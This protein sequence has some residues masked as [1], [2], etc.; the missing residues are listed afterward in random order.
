MNHALKLII[1][2]SYVHAIYAGI[3]DTKYYTVAT[4]SIPQE[5][6]VDAESKLN[7]TDIKDFIKNEVNQYL[8][9]QA[10]KAVDYVVQTFISL[11]QDSDSLFDDLTII[12]KFNSTPV[13]R[14]LLQ[15]LEGEDG[16]GTNSSYPAPNGTS[17][18]ETLPELQPILQEL[19]L[20]GL[21]LSGPIASTPYATGTD[22]APGEDLPLSSEPG[23][24]P[25]GTEQ[26][27]TADTLVQYAETVAAYDPT[28]MYTIT[29]TS[30]YTNN[31]I[32][33]VPNPGNS[34]WA[35]AGAGQATNVENDPIKQRLGQQQKIQTQEMLDF[36]RSF[37]EYERIAVS[38]GLL[39][40][41]LSDLISQSGGNPANSTYVLVALQSQSWDQM[42][43]LTSTLNSN[44]FAQQ[45]NARQL[46]QINVLSSTTSLVVPGEGEALNVLK[47]SSPSLQILVGLTYSNQTQTWTSRVKHYSDPTH[48]DY[49]TAIYFTKPKNV[50]PGDRLNP[51]IQPTS[52]VYCIYD[53]QVEYYTS[54]VG[55]PSSYAE[56]VTAKELVDM[57]PNRTFLE[58]YDDEHGIKSYYAN[59]DDRAKNILTIEIKQTAIE[60]YIGEISSTNNALNT[61]R[62]GMG[63]LV[64][65]SNPTSIPDA[66]VDFSLY[67]V[68]STNHYTF[69]VKSSQDYTY[70]QYF[71][72]TINKVLYPGRHYGIEQ[73]M[74]YY[75]DINFVVPDGYSVDQG[76]LSDHTM[77]YI[78]VDQR[79][80][81]DPNVWTNPCDI[82]GNVSSYLT[83]EC[84]K[85]VQM[86]FCSPIVHDFMNKK[87]ILV[88][89]RVPIPTHDESDT[90]Q[91]FYVSILLKLISPRTQ[92]PVVYTNLVTSIRL[93]NYVTHCQQT[94][95][96]NVNLDN[97]FVKLKL[98]LGLQLETPFSSAFTV[99]DFLDEFG[100][101]TDA[102]YHIDLTGS[103]DVRS[104]TESL[105]TM[106]A[107]GDEGFFATNP[108]KFVEI[109]QV[110]T[111]HTLSNDT[112]NTIEGILKRSEA[113][114]TTPAGTENPYTQINF[115]SSITDLCSEVFVTEY[116]QSKPCVMRHE[117]K[118]SQV[119]NPYFAH[120]IEGDERDIAWLT[121]II[122]TSSA[123]VD[124]ATNISAY[125]SPSVLSPSY[126]PRYDKGFWIYP[127]FQWP[128]K[129]ILDITDYVFLIVSFSVKT[130]TSLPTRRRLLQINNEM[131]APIEKQYVDEESTEAD[132][133]DEPG[134]PSE[135]SEPSEP[136]ET[137]ETRENRETSET[138]ENGTRNQTGQTHARGLSNPSDHH[139]EV[140]EDQSVQEDDVQYQ[141]DQDYI[142]EADLEQQ[143][144]MD[145]MHEGDGR[146]LLAHPRS[147]TAP[148]GRLHLPVRHDLPTRPKH[149]YLHHR[150]DE[151]PATAHSVKEEPKRDRHVGRRLIGDYTIDE[152]NKESFKDRRYRKKISIY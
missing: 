77:Y 150:G 148:V 73:E 51:C 71:S 6:L 130:D 101:P 27:A 14:R 110:Y 23:L 48:D 66:I 22:P 74:A 152:E 143:E 57:I 112:K 123:A 108:Q 34:S 5:S 127:A 138:T 113:F 135:P 119:V 151:P 81:A 16:N 96:P 121:N 97:R 12:N 124:L 58:L 67:E 7:G 59:A 70:L 13:G 104:I 141:H 31:V 21:D 4:I 125:K 44:L 32:Y 92:F 63:L 69:S 83:E 26:N 131:D 88:T 99:R 149:L 56:F 35:S 40:R 45:I 146:R 79:T 90:S 65:R 20:D 11:F 55:L 115:L 107:I 116:N 139:T 54:I 25:N 122:G 126:N 19:G 145:G 93:G 147:R 75:A 10:S 24:Q 2:L 98:S 120:Y 47:Q 37:A 133:P 76:S 87:G 142:S 52:S 61:Y 82:N 68:L 111:L 103:Q 129:N 140:Q 53:M 43:L 144:Q 3:Y 100:Q 118:D 8:Q 89:I 128:G 80:F 64:L 36:W 95:L 91:L 102:A 137:N 33:Y 50:Q 105:F 134:E 84:K 9:S 49:I 28:T 106:N 41:K 42:Q 17:D 114:F 132:E 60:L 62:F 72:A 38:Q 46:L 78:G 29:D 15:W 18:N 85:Q 94:L 136:K 117:I 30:S 1:C 86:N 109:Q 39:R